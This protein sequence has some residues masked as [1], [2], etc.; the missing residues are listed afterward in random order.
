MRRGWIAWRTLRSGW[1]SRWRIEDGGHG[2]AVDVAAAEDDADAAGGTESAAEKRGD[3][4]GARGFD[5]E[6][7]AVKEEANGVANVVLGDGLHFIHVFEHEGK[8]VISEGGGAGSVGD[9]GG[10]GDGLEGFGAERADGVVGDFGFDAG[11]A[12]L[13]IYS[14]D[15]DGRAGEKAA[16]AAG[17]DDPIEIR[18]LFAEFGGSSPLPCDDVEVIERRD[19]GEAVPGLEFS[20]DF[21]AGGIGGFAENDGGA[22]AFGGLALGGGGV[23]RHD[24]GGANTEKLTGE[25]DGLGMVAGGKSNDAGSFLGGGEARNGVEGAAKFEGADTL[26]VFAFAEDFGADEAIQRARGRNGRDVGV[27][28]EGFAS[29]KDARV[30]VGFHA[31]KG[32]IVAC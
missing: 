24:N 26:E 8:S 6:F 29:G 15:R 32:Q 25:G 17:R 27:T 12:G 22:V 18:N 5:D 14:L 3:A 21:F 28:A 9:G 19:E 31:K 13:G 1:R 16:A 4:E 20:G 10:I 7:H 2:G 11:D 23:A 30:E